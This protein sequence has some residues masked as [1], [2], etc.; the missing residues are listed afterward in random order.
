MLNG[1]F[2]AFQ[3]F[4]ANS[5]AMSFDQRY[6]DK[7]TLEC[8]V[9][10]NSDREPDDIEQTGSLISPDKPKLFKAGTIIESADELQ[11]NVLYT[12]YMYK[13]AVGKSYCY[14][15]GRNNNLD[16]ALPPGYDSIY[17]EEDADKNLFQHKYLV[18]SK[19]SFLLTYMVQCKIRIEFP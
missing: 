7:T 9:K 18:F 6:R 11:E 14:N 12:F 16:I 1:R 5:S 13:V 19:E 2:D 10:A 15:K 3:V 4:Q 17:L 8:W